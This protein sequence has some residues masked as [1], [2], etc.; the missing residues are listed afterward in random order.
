MTM[1]ST[2]AHIKIQNE[3]SNPFTITQ[4]LKQGDGLAPTLFNISLEYVIRKMS[5]DKS[6]ILFYKMNQNEA[7]TYD[8][9]IMSTT[10]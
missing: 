6:G 7:Y 4:R 3:L 5:V 9:N 10:I 2:E 8:V 1:E